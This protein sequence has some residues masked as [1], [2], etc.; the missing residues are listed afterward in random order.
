MN[1][2]LRLLRWLLRLLGIVNDNP[3]PPSLT[4]EIDMA[5]A[6]L[7]WT[8]PTERVDGRP[9]DPSDIASTRIEMSA[10]G[11][12]NFVEAATVPPTEPQVFVVEDLSVGDY[13]F[14]ATV[15]DTDGRNSAPAE[16]TGTVL[17]NPNPVGDLAVTIS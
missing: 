11:G 6:T 17:G 8:L 9:L 16:A 12:A 10:D 13:V 5:R 14:R 4:L 1:W 3:R 2:F 15:F 7:T